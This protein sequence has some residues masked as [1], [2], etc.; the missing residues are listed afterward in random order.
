[1]SC[2]AVPEER[3]PMLDPSWLHVLIEAPRV[4]QKFVRGSVS[5]VHE[6]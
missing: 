1:M 4:F 2:M 5:G 3:A 6:V